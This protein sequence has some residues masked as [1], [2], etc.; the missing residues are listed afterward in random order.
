MVDRER[1]LAKL[2]ELD[3]YLGELRSIAPGTLEAYLKI[4]TRRA[5]ERLLQVSIEAAIDA[6]AMLVKGLRLGVPADE[7]DLVE[8]LA[9]RGVIS[10]AMAA[11]LD[12]MRGFRNVL[13]HQYGRVD[14]SMVFDTLRARLGDFDAFKREVLGCLQEGHEGGPR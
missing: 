6:C 5:C 11:T 10:P 2:D 14:D 7:R 4:E 3:G 12:R 13:V 8:K 1:L 9:R